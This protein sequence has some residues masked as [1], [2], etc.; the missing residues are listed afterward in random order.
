M[1]DKK[2]LKFEL[3]KEDIKIKDVKIKNI[4]QKD[5]LN[6]EIYAIS[7]IYPNRNKSHFKTESLSDSID[8]CYNKPILG[9][10][11]YSKN[12][13]EEHNGKVNYDNDNG[14]LYWDT[15]EK[16]EIPL[17]LVRESDLVEVCK[18]DNISWLKINCAIW[19]SY[20]YKQ[21]KKLLKS[22]TKKIS[23]EVEVLESYIDENGIEIITKFILSGIT[24][25]GDNISE[26]IP[27]AHL[28]I[29]DLIEN[30]LFKK[31][32]EKLQ[33]AY[34]NLN[35]KKT[36]M[37]VENFTVHIIKNKK[38]EGKQNMLTYNQIIE[39]A[40]K[41][42]SLNY[43]NEDGCSKYSV[44]DISDEFLI[45]RNWEEKK[46]TK[47]PFSI[48]E[49]EMTI[50]M[51]SQEEVLSGWTSF[52]DKEITVDN[53]NISIAQL[54]EKF[55]AIKDLKY[56]VS[57]EEKE[58]DVNSL[59]DKYSELLKDYEGYKLE[60]SVKE[61]DFKELEEKNEVLKADF[62]TKENECK[63][64]EEKLSVTDGECKEFKEKF[65][66]KET[67]IKALE[68]KL[69]VLKQEFSA[70]ETEL[71]TL[72]NKIADEKFASIEEVALSLTKDEDLDEES[73]NKILSNC[74]ERKYASIEDVEKDI[75]YIG[76]KKRL[77]KK[78]KESKSFSIGLPTSTLKTDDEEK[79]SPFSK[80]ELYVK[81]Q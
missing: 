11:N 59:F 32:V 36:N 71:T 55:S 15:S 69:D 54:V 9:Y 75:A 6:L 51:E 77:E 76:L 10:F 39:L 68:D 45:L 42:L 7:D 58:Y 61:V 56:T 63:D 35:E 30:T 65:V 26:G 60:F 24:I 50:N 13:F 4:L 67:D 66:A 21:V 27:D 80:L 25:L 41:N 34:N 46:Y 40:E 31:K 3:S 20:C 22:N 73:T 19:T 57:I 23:V 38:E 5:F 78:E 37:P 1:L 48:S 16:G 17:G 81:K 8:S 53:E 2:I 74:K 29:L 49:N 28:N 52:M 12:D 43:K 72:Q 64:L 44:S 62:T 47:V 70:K 33:F 79:E 18:K 14:N